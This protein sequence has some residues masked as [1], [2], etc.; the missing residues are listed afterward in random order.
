[1]SRKLLGAVAGARRN[2]PLNVL[3]RLVAWELFQLFCQSLACLIVFC[4]VGRMKDL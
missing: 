4:T 3:L 1:M 2:I